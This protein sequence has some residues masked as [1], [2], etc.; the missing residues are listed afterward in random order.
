MKH[1][2]IG[3]KQKLELQEDWAWSIVRIQGV[4]KY[5]CNKCIYCEG[6]K[7]YHPIGKYGG[8]KGYGHPTKFICF[9]WTKPNKPSMAKRMEGMSP[10]DVMSGVH[11]GNERASY[12]GEDTNDW[13]KDHKQQKEE[14]GNALA[15]V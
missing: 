10:E 7:E 5:V 12:L 6:C 2:C 8:A 15:D 4:K 14:L 1:Y 11:M 3:H 9:N 13:G